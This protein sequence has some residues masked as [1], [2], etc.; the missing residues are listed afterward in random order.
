MVNEATS[1]R[2]R[3]GASSTGRPGLLTLINSYFVRHAQTLFYSLG[4]L[5]RAPF[6]MLMTAAVIGIA[7]AL[8]AGMHQLLQNAQLL[9]GKLDDAT[10]ISL[11][12]KKAVT[13]QQARELTHKLGNMPEI[14]RVRLITREQALEEFKQ[15][16]GFGDALRALD[17]NPLPHVIVINPALQH[18]DAAAGR[19]L[20]ERLQGMIQ[21]DAAQLDVEWIKRLYAILEII[22][23]GV[24]ILAALLGMAVLLVVGNTIR[25]AIQNRR[26]E[27]VVIKLIG[28]TD[29]FIRRPFLYTGFWYGLFGAL[30]AFT[31]V[32]IAL[33]LLSDP[34]RQLGELY[35]NPV[36]LTRMNLETS[37]YLLGAGI[38]L[39]LGGS[40][41]A[42]GRHLRDIEPR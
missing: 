10:Q 14:G 35:H 7:L 17:E 5:L 32:N 25:L 29:A 19:K 34:V 27:I 36:S 20:L 11:F 40:W 15:N 37:A 3:E 38:L 1:R 12:L 16:A 13:E 21:V 23:R 9:S 22:K 41:L 42:V 4:Q 31:L 33:Y 28:G 8:P 26:D 18:T 39:G 2:N 24:W 6:S 30:I